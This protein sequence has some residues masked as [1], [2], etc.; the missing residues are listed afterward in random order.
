MND[1]ENSIMRV[2]ET[3]RAAVLEKDVDAFMRLYDQE[4]R[5]FD[6]GAYGHTKALQR[7]GR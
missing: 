2:I 3:Y 4:V 6:R 1:L 7:G 5:V